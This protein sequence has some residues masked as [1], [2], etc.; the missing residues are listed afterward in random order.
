[1]K[2][3]ESEVRTGGAYQEQQIGLQFGSGGGI[4]SDY[5]SRG[6]GDMDRIEEVEDCT[7][8]VVDRRRAEEMEDRRRAEGFQLSR[9]R[10]G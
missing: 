7:T 10:R 6:E 3:K 8:E 9:S 4:R 1:M 2:E 5:T